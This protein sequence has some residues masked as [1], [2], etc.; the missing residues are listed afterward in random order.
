MSR[1]PAL[2]FVMMLCL[3][4]GFCAVLAAGEGEKELFPPID[5]FESG[6]L[7]VSD[8]HTV[9]Y[10]CCGNPKGKPV[11]VLHGG[12]GV[13]CYPRMRQYFNPEKYLIVLHDQRGAGR[14][15]PHGEIRENTTG[16]LVS[17]IERLRKHLKLGKVVIFGGSWGTTLGVAYAETYPDNVSAMVLRGVFTG[18]AAEVEFHYRGAARFF[19]EEHAALIAALPDPSRG[20]DPEY[21]LELANHE[22]PALRMKVLDALAVY[23]LKLCTLNNP[24]ESIH[25]ML[26]NF[27]DD[28]HRRL[29]T[30]DLF[31]TSN[32]YFL[33]EGQLLRDA[34]RLKE[35][36]AILIHGRYDMA[37]QPGS[38]YSLHKA[39]PRSKLVIVE[40]AGHSESEEAITAE[41]LKAT[42][43]FE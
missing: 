30:I 43:A 37:T 5:P 40:E 28:A 22:D 35:I 11:L 7:K 15:T 10:E 25:E 29:A 20:P 32:L 27:P 34:P 9:Y 19:P 4:S 38:A 18:T 21:L 1:L 17:D 31:Y 33:E 23:E 12:P 8:L 13:G 42:A 24:I 16:D 39:M 2:S 14:S 36:P 3:L 41:I 6:M 26:K